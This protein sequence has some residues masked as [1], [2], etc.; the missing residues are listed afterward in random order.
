[1]TA[2]PKVGMLF[3]APTPYRNPFLKRLAKREDVE[4]KVIFLSKVCGPFDWHSDLECDFPHV[5]L[6]LPEWLKR[7]NYPQW[8]HGELPRLF[9]REKFGVVYIGGYFLLSM[10]Y[11][12]V[13]CIRTGTP[14]II[15]VENHGRGH[16]SSLLRKLVNRALIR[17]LVRGASAH[18]AVGSYAR[19][20]LVGW[21][22]EPDSVSIILNSPDVDG[23][24]QE[25][26]R[27]IGRREKIREEL[28]FGSG[29]LLLFVGRMVPEKGVEDLLDAYEEVKRDGSV[30]D[31]QLLL[32]GEGPLLQS[33]KERC[34]RRGMK[35]VVF[36]GFVAP[37]ELYPYYAAADAFVL[38]SRYEPFGVVVHE[39]ASAGLPL[40]VSD[41]C[42]AAA[43]LVRDGENGFLFEAGDS[44]DLAR[45]I[46]RLFNDNK[47]EE[48]GKNSRA[49]AR[50]YDYS[51]EEEQFMRAINRC[52]DGG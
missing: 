28:G 20:R 42:G 48:M 51:H 25:T 14:Y 21:G 23:W 13:W 10:I 40:L 1:M 8:I 11:A 37:D 16:Q 9:R 45:A 47:W 44:K 33:L 2:R 26:D 5:F 43:E 17:P 4:I 39:A 52:L 29:P 24:V 31:L 15:G 12:A 49:L 30:E 7:K 19:D 46:R 22:I 18:I 6:E 50:M 41:C 34:S 27:Y 32:I 3:S 36:G 38:P 35:D